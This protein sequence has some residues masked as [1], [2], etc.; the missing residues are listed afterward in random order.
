[1]FER[2]GATM[3]QTRVI[4]GLGLLLSFSALAAPAVQIVPSPHAGS[5]VAAAAE[6]PYVVRLESRSFA[7]LGRAD[8]ATLSDE[9]VFVQFQRT[10]TTEE[11]ADLSAAGIVFHESLEP[12][13]YLVSMPPSAAEAV[14]R[15]PLFRGAEAIQPT[16]KLS[17]AIFRNEIPDHARRPDD[18]IAVYFRFYENVTLDQALSA[19]DA[20]G[21]TVA[22]A[23]RDRL[24]F[25]SRMPATATREQIVAA[26]RNALVRT[27]FEI[28]PPPARVNALA[29]SISNVPPV[30]A[31]PYSLTG[32]GV[33]VGIWDGGQVLD[34]HQALT[35]RVTTRQ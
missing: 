2:Q 10:L 33:A 21:V 16:D 4:W 14:Q 7:P 27:A 24:L 25:G 17:A 11:Q 6:D 22:A 32:S 9:K 8:T 29:A 3:R 28:P 23:D 31:A 20:A 18:G 34:T 15:S 19:L 5:S 30:Q 13:T 12:F 1:M 26:C 35:S